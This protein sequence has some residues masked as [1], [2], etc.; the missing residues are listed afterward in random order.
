MAQIH[1]GEFI[2]K[3]M[4]EK[5]L[6]ANDLQKAINKGKSATYNIFERE[7]L[8]TDEIEVISKLLGINIFE[9]LART[10]QAPH[11]VEYRI[12]PRKDQRIDDPERPYELNQAPK[13]ISITLEVTPEKSE[14]ILKILQ[15]QD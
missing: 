11:S 4:D 3:K 9:E 1:L 6:T 14:K 10:S 8:R 15:G 2:K 12:P 5:H 13:C 7:H